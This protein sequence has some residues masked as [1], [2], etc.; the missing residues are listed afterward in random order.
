MSSFGPVLQRL[1]RIETELTALANR[2]AAAAPIAQQQAQPEQYTSSHAAERGTERGVALLALPHPVSVSGA[3]V[4]AAGWCCSLRVMGNELV[5]CVDQ[6]L[7]PELT[8]SLV[9]SMH[10]SRIPWACISV[11]TAAQR[12]QGPDTPWENC[13]TF[14][15]MLVSCRCEFTLH[16]CSTVVLVWG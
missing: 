13:A 3:S 7:A 15:R 12:T 2:A 1:A 9:H 8:C 6:R 4:A 10:R 14:L 16:L 5:L 11:Q